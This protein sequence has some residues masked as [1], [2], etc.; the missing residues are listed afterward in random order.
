MNLDLADKITCSLNT[1][2][3]DRQRPLVCRSKPIS[4]HVTFSYAE[5]S[6][7]HMKTLG[8]VLWN[9][10]SVPAFYCDF[11]NFF[12]LR[13]LLAASCQKSPCVN[14]SLPAATMDS[15]PVQTCSTVFCGYGIQGVFILGLMWEAQMLLACCA[16]RKSKK[17]IIFSTLDRV[18]GRCGSKL[19]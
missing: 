16:W 14:K 3:K 17:I 5:M 8:I 18:K 10:A 4:A 6:G 12:A 15:A 13:Y 7:C 1:V 2:P 19:G 9:S 11:G